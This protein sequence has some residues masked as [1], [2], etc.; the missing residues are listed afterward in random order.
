MCYSFEASITTYLFGM[1]VALLYTI[2]NG[3]HK[4]LILPIVFTQI[5]LIEAIIWKFPWLNFWASVAGLLIIML[6]PIASMYSYDAMKLLI[7]YLILVPYIYYYSFKYQNFSTVIE[8]KSGN[9][10]WNWLDMRGLRG[11]LFAFFLLAPVLFK[12]RYLGFIFG[13]GT[14]LYSYYNYNQYGT[15]STNWCFWANI[16]WLYILTFIKF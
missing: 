16:I 12:G 11:P 14:L 5:Q 15:V 7:P 10:L 8:P 6:E 1:S 2:Y 13:A 3:Y 4:F 9:L